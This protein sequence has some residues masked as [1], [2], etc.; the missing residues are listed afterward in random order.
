MLV[1]CF[2]IVS[3]FCF[4]MFF[5]FYLSNA[6]LLQAHVILPKQLSKHLF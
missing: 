1:Q 2:F 6:D 5:F 4:S 3:Y